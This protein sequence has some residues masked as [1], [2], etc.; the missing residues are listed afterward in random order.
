MKSKAGILFLLASAISLLG[1]A[2][3]QLV[4][5]ANAFLIAGILLMAALF[6]GRY[7]TLSVPAKNY[8]IFSLFGKRWRARSEGLTWWLSGLEKYELHSK[9]LDRL[10]VETVAKSK[11][12]LGIKLRGSVEFVVDP[13]REML[14]KYDETKR[15]QKGAIT[16]SIKDELGILAGTKNAADFVK[17]RRA[18]TLIINCRLRLKE[19]PHENPSVFGSGTKE[20][21]LPKMLD[22][23]D[24]YADKVQAVLNDEDKKREERSRI[25]ESYGIDILVFN[26]TDPDYT[27]KT[28][29]AF[30]EA[31]QAEAK[32]KAAKAELDLAVSFEACSQKGINAAQV[33][34]GKAKREVHSIEGKPVEINIGGNK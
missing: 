20:I 17:K 2:M 5:Y 8:A 28:N 13:D 11:D 19:M 3:V 25:E 26:L 7:F 34:V 12:L 4:P 30:E 6:F 29:A 18:I 33:S 16:D 21:S 24:K 15:N 23:Y 27:D 14:L 31:K 9:E 10:E 1:Y 22:F 32:K